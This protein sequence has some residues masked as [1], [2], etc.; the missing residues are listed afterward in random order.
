[1]RIKE[2]IERLKTECPSFRGRVEGAASLAAI[3]PSTVK[4]PSAFIIPVAKNAE[5]NSMRGIHSQKITEMFGVTIFVGN[6]KDSR[7]EAAQVDLEPIADEVYNALAGWTPSYAENP[8]D[9]VSSKTVNFDDM[10]LCSLEIY[11]TDYHKRK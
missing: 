9:L 5:P 8:V 11:K 1:M 3:K 2:W 4:T 10:V 7:G 6:V